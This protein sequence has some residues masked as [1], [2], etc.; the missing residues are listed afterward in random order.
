MYTEIRI[1]PFDGNF[2]INPDITNNNNYT[3]LAT[4]RQRNTADDTLVMI[5]TNGAYSVATDFIR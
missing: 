1:G 5:A 2:C 4:T 3:G